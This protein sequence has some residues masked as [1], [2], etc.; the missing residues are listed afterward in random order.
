MQRSASVVTA[1]TTSGLAL[2]NPDLPRSGS[3]YESGLLE[4]AYTVPAE[5]IF[6]ECLAN[7]PYITKGCLDSQTYLLWPTYGPAH[8]P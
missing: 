4:S 1:A 6:T 3:H 2:R 7:E 8:S 5:T